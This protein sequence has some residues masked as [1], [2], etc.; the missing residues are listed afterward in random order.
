MKLL[1]VLVFR[2]LTGPTIATGEAGTAILLASA[3]EL[4]SF[5]FF[6][7]GTVKEICTFGCRQVAS[8]AGPGQREIVRLSDGSYLCH[9][10]T[11]PDRTSVT[12]ITDGDYQARVAFT[13]LSRVLDEFRQQHSATAMAA[14]HDMEIP[15]PALTELLARY[16]D[17]ARADP[18]SKVERDL[19][20]TKSVMIKNIDQL[21]ERGDSLERLVE[22]SDDLSFQSRAFM[23]NAK[24]MNSCCNI[25]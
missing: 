6:Q 16:Q 22:K 8:R 15:F 11:H 20:E 10:Y 4:S 23:I 19:E 25:L 2:Q 3:F 5:G 12:V 17:P 18:I 7:R 24:K 14:T 13:L 1:G 9:V 21:L